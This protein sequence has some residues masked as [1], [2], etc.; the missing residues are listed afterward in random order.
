MGPLNDL[1][2]GYDGSFTRALDG[3]PTHGLDVWVARHEDRPVT[4]LLT[5]DRDEDRHVTLVATAPAARGRGAGVG[6]AGH[7]P[8][9]TP[10][11]GAYGAAR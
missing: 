11:I 9:A 10:A 5:F 8:G 2:Y 7:G 1:A 4:C 3:V 6:A